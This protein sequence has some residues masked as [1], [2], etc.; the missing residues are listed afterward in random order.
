[1][2]D[3]GEGE[4]GEGSGTHPLI[5]G[6][7]R[8]A[9]KAVTLLLTDPHP[10]YLFVHTYNINIQMINSHKLV[11]VSLICL[12]STFCIISLSAGPL[13]LVSKTSMKRYTQN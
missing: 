4:S 12:C 5:E 6:L 2:L 9:R 7:N 8:E 3:S 1:M 11:F 10:E 13:L